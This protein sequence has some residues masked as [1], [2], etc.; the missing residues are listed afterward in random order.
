MILEDVLVGVVV[1]VLAKDAILLLLLIF[2]YRQATMGDDEFPMVSILIA[3]RNEEASIQSCITSLTSQDYPRDKVEILVG[4]DNSS[5]ETLAVLNELKQQEDSARLK[6]FDIKEQLLS[7]PGKQNTLALIGRHANG[8]VLLFTDAD[9]VQR[10]TWIRTMV[11]VL[12]A[13]YD[14]VT[15]VTALRE[16]K[17]IHRVQS[18]EWLQS[19]GMVKVLEDL[20]IHVTSIGNN[21]GMSAHVYEQVGGFEGIPE[22]ITEDY[23]MYRQALK[24]GFKSFHIFEASVLATSEP[25][26]TFRETVVQRT[27]W[28]H[29]AMQLPFVMV[30]LLFLGSIQ[31]PLLLALV[32]VNPLLGILGILISVLLHFA[33]IRFIAARLK[34]PLDWKSTLLFDF[35][36]AAVNLNAFLNFIFRRSKTWKGRSYK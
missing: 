5:D 31:I 25:R 12:A 27:R 30:V 22:S 9:T 11:G 35:F 20:G 33:F 28:M 23:E 16:E 13:G 6:V 7:Q 2:N 17:W 3:A 36:Q 10:P 26:P 8:T 29:G 32:I 15:G 18:V 19:I 21:M 1:V 4:N 24:A 14:L 34:Y